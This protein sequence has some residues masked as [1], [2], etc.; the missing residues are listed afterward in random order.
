MPSHPVDRAWRVAAVGAV[1]HLALVGA[2]L[3]RFGFDPTWFVHFRRD[4]SVLPVAR[5]ALGEDVLVPHRDGHDGQAF[6]LLARDPLLLQGNKL[7]PYLDR[8]AYRAQR[9]LYPALA[10]PWRLAGEMGLVWGLLVT[11][12]VVVF[13][14][15]CLAMRLAREL[16]VHERASL[17][18]ALNPAVV[19]AVLL[20]ASDALMMAL[21]VWMLLCLIRGRWGRAAV[22]AAAASLAKEQALLGIFSLLLLWRR[23][24]RGA[25]LTVGASAILAAGS[26]A[27]YERWR[28]GWPPSQIQ[29]FTLPAWGYVDAYLRGWRHFGN[30]ADA[31]VAI[32]LW[33][34]AWVAIKRWRRSPSPTNALCLP[35]AL[36][37][38]FL[39]AQVVDSALNAVRAIGPLVTFLA[40]DAGVR[41]QARSSP[42]TGLS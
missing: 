42:S 40:L 5:K 18:F 17:L 22:A 39:G 37:V 41:R 24:A 1:V 6:W 8:P 29:E 38:P 15:G 34:V 4:G 28:L 11:N 16:G 23:P 36:Y 2:Y 7:R 27:L 14:G 9:I 31:A 21:L 33:A 30:W 13:T 26:W 12:L 35:Y 10:A 25:R 20:D 3:A 19:V 32:A